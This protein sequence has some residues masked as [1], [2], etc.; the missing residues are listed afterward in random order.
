[1][2]LFNAFLRRLICQSVI[3]SKNEVWVGILSTFPEDRLGLEMENYSSSAQYAPYRVCSSQDEV[4]NMKYSC[5]QI[6]EHQNRK[7]GAGNSHHNHHHRHFPTNSD[8]PRIAMVNDRGNISGKTRPD[9]TRCPEPAQTRESFGM[10]RIIQK[11]GLYVRSTWK[12][13]YQMTLSPLTTRTEG[14]IPIDGSKWNK[15]H[16]RGFEVYI[17]QIPHSSFPS[18]A[19]FVCF[20][21]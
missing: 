10:I 15:N 16:N 13:W 19:F 17:P 5:T 11:K 1:M 14:I 7:C 2:S 20:A 6:K 8:P 12:E 18:F 3:V 21:H 9:D 4:W